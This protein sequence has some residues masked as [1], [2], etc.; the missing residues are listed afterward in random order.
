MSNN[1]N[2]ANSN[3][4]PFQMSNRGPRPGEVPKERSK[5]ARATLLKIWSYLKRQRQALWLVVIGTA[6]VSCFTLLGP[7]LIG[8]TIDH[9]IVP[10]KLS[11]F[12]HM[13]L[14]LLGVYLLGAVFTWLQQYVARGWPRIP[15]GTCAK[16]FLKNINSCRFRFLTNGHMGN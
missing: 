1:S 3:P 5:N 4:N 13:G 9:Y 7:Y 8:K 10:H 2:Q 11:G 6:L 15:S 12:L 16:I 14:A